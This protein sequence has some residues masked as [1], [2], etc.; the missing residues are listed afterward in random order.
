M[1]NWLRDKR[2][3][4]ILSAC[5]ACLLWAETAAAEHSAKPNVQIIKADGMAEIAQ[6]GGEID[7]A[8]GSVTGGC[9]VDGG[10]FSLSGGTVQYMSQNEGDVRISG[11]SV[12]TDCRVAGGSIFCVRRNSCKYYTKKWNGQYDR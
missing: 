5:I 11:G 3:L 8:D 7:M 2:V 6:K 1:K 4:W 10:V 9:T 12:T